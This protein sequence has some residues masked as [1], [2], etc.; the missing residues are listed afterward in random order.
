MFD[1]YAYEGTHNPI[2]NI[3][4]AGGGNRNKCVHECTVYSACML[5]FHLSIDKKSKL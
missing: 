5:L 2:F 3:L 4:N 1:C